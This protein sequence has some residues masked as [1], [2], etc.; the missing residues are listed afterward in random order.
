MGA[1]VMITADH[2][3]AENML[4]KSGKQQT[5]HTTNRVPFILA[6]DEKFSVKL[7][8]DGKLSDVT[9]TV[10]DVMGIKKPIEFEANS[11]IK[12]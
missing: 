6:D 10:I 2:G 1:C 12:N 5:A 3:N 11:L 8:S 4:T 7:R 9:A